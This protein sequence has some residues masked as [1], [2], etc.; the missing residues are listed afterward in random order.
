LNS[1]P[2]LTE[3]EEKLPR[4]LGMWGLWLLVVNGFVGAGIFGL[5]SGAYA[6]AGEY[7]I[8]I[9]AL[10][11]LLMLPIILCFSELGSIFRGTGGPVR[12]GSEAFGPFIGF[13]A[14]WLF[15]VA[16]LISFAANSVLLVDSIGYFL[17]PAAEG[18]GRIIS[19]AIIIGGLT[20]IN[21]LGSV[22]SIRSL[23]LFTVLKFSVLL[24]LVFGGMVVLGTQI[25]PSFE[26]GVPPISDLGAA[27]LLLVYA[28]VGFEGAVVPAG[29]ARKPGRD[30][31]MALLLGL[32]MVVV[33]YMLIQLVTESAVTGLATSTSPLLDA[34]A[35]LFGTAGAIILMIGVV[36]SV[37]GNLIGSLFSA[38][39]LTYALALDGS[40]PKW[41]AKVHPK[42]LTP[43]NSVI[44]Y[45]VFAFIA[46]SMGTF[47]FL[48]A[49]TV[50]A[51][52]FLYIITC[53]AVP[54]LRKK[55]NEKSPFR[56]KGGVTIPALGI[57]ACI[58]LML[59]VSFNS[60]WL[61]ALFI[62][63]GTLLYLMARRQNRVS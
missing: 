26:S 54:V 46:A 60:I 41:F 55:L 51:R 34:S 9:Y 6:L 58:W 16:R 35:A 43:A 29:E 15:Y 33:L 20:F 52:L 25:L 19:L 1:S 18:A 27:A 3:K 5:P 21:V 62:V 24:F 13:Q 2:I 14:G 22:E 49:M 56:L 17:S 32:G 44:F 30:M 59:Q 40:L 57:A 45:G 38:P 4:K 47:I 50:L 8:W 39:R 36:T 61:T 12:Y 42:W 28:F 7:S 11:A 10:C 37:T 23:A 53:G 63:I 48:A 31:P